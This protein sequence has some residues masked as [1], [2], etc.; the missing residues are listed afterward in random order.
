MIARTFACVILAV[1]TPGIPWALAAAGDE[2]T[3]QWSDD[4]DALAK[5]LAE[6]HVK[7]F[8][9]IDRAK[10]EEAV[11]ET[12]RAIPSLTDREILVR[13]LKLAALLEDGHTM[14][15]PGGGQYTLRQYP[16]ALIWLADGLYVGAVA[17]EQS[18][19]L[20]A[21]VVAIGKTPIAEAERQISTLFASENES[22][23]KDRTRRWLV[24]ADALAAIGLI[25]DAE[26]G[27]WTVVDAKGV[28]RQVTL[29]PLGARPPPKIVRGGESPGQETIP[30]RRAQ[31]PRYGHEWLSDGATLYC[32]YDSCSNLPD[33]PVA[34]WAKDLFAAVDEKTPERLVFDLR[35]NGGGNSLLALPLLAG[36]I[37][38]PA[39]N[40]KGRLFVL[41][42]PGTY[43]S[44]MMN[45]HQFRTRTNATLVG[46]PTGGSP[47][48]F[49]EVK[50]LALPHSKWVVQYSTKE[51]RQTND[52]ATTVAP[53]VTVALT[54]ADF[55]AGRDSVMD[56]VLASRPR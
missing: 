48:H 42:G 55:F 9:K 44:A 24:N 6:K 11:A 14:V 17:A 47:N 3:Q 15:G 21:R 41:I 20:G 28:Q 37:A 27:R 43:S 7:P 25:D 45:A 31:R 50:T 33:R 18:D 29:A 32:W 56:V 23:R 4:L 13:F 35:R 8:H 38:R 52:G 5:C 51:F 34:A 36:V 54:A 22:A 46:Q 1:A 49:G 53:D 30:S 16:L 2:R 40:Q 12:R 10:F 26:N 39:V 19:L